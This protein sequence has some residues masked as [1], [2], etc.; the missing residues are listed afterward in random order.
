VYFSRSAHPVAW[1]EFRYVGPVNARWDHHLPNAAGDAVLQ[2]RGIYYAARDAKTCLAEAF[3]AT[4]RIDRAYQSP[5]LVV[6]RTVRA[7]LML[8]V[9]GDFATRMG[10]SMAIQ[11]G[12]RARARSWA[13]DLYEAFP[14]AAG[15]LY[16]SSMHGGKPAFA[17]N[18]RALE[19]GPLFP[20]HP[21]FH[22]ALGDDVMLDVLKHAARDLGYGLR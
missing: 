12:S 16:A 9:S 4:R 6:C 7:I 21:E 8:D 1:H 2:G 15:I 22:R 3:Q 18:E 14:Q 11:S 13:Q 10:A 19:Q 17:I 20:A 5:W